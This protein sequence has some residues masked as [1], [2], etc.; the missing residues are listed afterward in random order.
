MFI[1][2]F[3]Q[4]GF[5]DEKLKNKL[6]AYLKKCTKISKN[7]VETFLTYSWIQDE[8]FSL[9]LT[10]LPRSTF[11]K[12]CRAV[13]FTNFGSYSGEKK[14][15]ILIKKTTGNLIEGMVF[16]KVSR[17][18]VSKRTF[19]TTQIGPSLKEKYS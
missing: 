1:T 12:L 10:D 9:L 16:V 3:I 4:G 11:F 18:V 17:M 8:L 7:D 2:V 6:W 15:C 19:F 14:N 5:V 13:S